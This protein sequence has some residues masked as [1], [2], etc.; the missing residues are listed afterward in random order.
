[1]KH[2]KKLSL[3][4]QREARQV[5]DVTF[6]QLG[7]PELIKKIVVRWRRMYRDVGASE[8]TIRKADNSVTEMQILLSERLWPYMS[9][10]QRY[11]TLVHEV[12]HIVDVHRGN[13]YGDPHGPTWSTL[14][15][16]MGVAPKP[17]LRQLNVPYEALCK[18][19]PR[20]TN[21]RGLGHNRLRCPNSETE[22]LLALFD[23]EK[24]IHV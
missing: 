8:W 17:S 14:M 3:E 23:D 21:C 7:A 19:L 4:D 16:R 24:K 5:I 10:K 13:L 12:C 20:C 6:A 11:D 15:R 9:R 1:M 2:P 22:E 18:I